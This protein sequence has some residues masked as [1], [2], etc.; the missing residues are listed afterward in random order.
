VSE[1]GP[2]FTDGRSGTHKLIVLS[3]QM[4][5]A[6][7]DELLAVI[8]EKLVQSHRQGIEWH[9]SDL[10]DGLNLPSQNTGTDHQ[11]SIERA[12]HV[13]APR[14]RSIIGESLI[15]H[16][17]CLGWRQLEAFDQRPDQT[18]RRLAGRGSQAVV[19]GRVVGES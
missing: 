19:S 16:P 2:R 14:R 7:R 5:S 17:L 3:V 11:L 13:I 8:G 15:R 12:G 4:H 9:F 10:C 1:T 18:R 6:A